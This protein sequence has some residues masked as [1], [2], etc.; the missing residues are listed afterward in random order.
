VR[1]TAVYA[2][3]T[4]GRHGSGAREDGLRCWAAFWTAPIAWYRDHH[5]LTSHDRPGFDALL[6]D[7]RARKVGL[8]VVRWLDRLGLTCRGLTALLHE[9]LRR[10]VELLSVKEGFDLGIDRGRHVAR[11]LTSVADYEI[12]IQ[13]QN[14]VAGQEAA[15]AA[16]QRWGGWPKG[17]RRTVTAEQV[18]AREPQDAGVGISASA[19][20][21]GL[22][23]K[24]VYRVLGESG[25]R[26]RRRPRSG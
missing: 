5:P 15:R 26:P 9:L 1:P 14:I 7:V 11:M 6:A 19:R 4:G 17:R 10:R 2:R 24:T 8:V 13:S 18:A 22:T 21:M 12:E 16:G 3:D 23:R 20:A 25:F